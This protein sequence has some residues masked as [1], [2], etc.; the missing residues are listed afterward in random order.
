MPLYAIVNDAVE[1]AKEYGGGIAFASFTNALLRKLHPDPTSL[2][3]K[4]S[5]ADNTRVHQGEKFVH[6]GA[7]GDIRHL[8][9]PEGNSEKALATR[10][11]YPPFLVK[12]LVQEFGKSHAISIMKAS[13]IFPPVMARSR[14]PEAKA[15]KLSGEAIEDKEEKGMGTEVHSAVDLSPEMAASSLSDSLKRGKA[16]W[17]T[18]ES[19]PMALHAPLPLPYTLGVVHS[20]VLLQLLTQNDG[21]YITNGTPAGLL[22]RLAQGA[23]KRVLADSAAE[24]SRD[25]VLQVLD[26]CAAPGGK[27]LAV[28]DILQGQGRRVSLVMNDVNEAKKA[29]IAENLARFGLSQEVQLTVGDGASLSKKDVANQTDSFVGSVIEQNGF[30]I[31]VLDVPCSNAGV[32][33]RRPEARWRLKDG[34]FLK[35]LETTQFSLLKH[36]EEEL[37]SKTNRHAEI[38]YLT[39]SI[40]WG[41]DEGMVEK[42]CK[43]L[44]LEVVVDAENEGRPLRMK[45]LPGEGLKG[46]F[47]GGFG[48]ALR[49]KASPHM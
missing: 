40:L 8:P 26:V 36:A 22:A 45:V 37:L 7:D 28:W 30:D 29:R 47:D 42:A 34:V 1:L 21:W 41:E 33:G 13:N 9:L 27:G 25:P 46:A 6:G 20:D 17:E 49:R 3:K 14:I 43:E 15:P 5:E 19:L 10:L 35:E 11:S 39:C 12:A 23:A 32:L 38:W 31:V 24:E 4:A 2:D 44:G 18:V 16:S 48:C